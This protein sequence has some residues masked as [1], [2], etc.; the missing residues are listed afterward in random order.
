MRPSLFSVYLRSS[1]PMFL[2]P[3]IALQAI[4]AANSLRDVHVNRS[5][6][7]TLAVYFVALTIGVLG[8]GITLCV[9]HLPSWR[10]Q[11]L[12]RGTPSTRLFDNCLLASFI[13]SLLAVIA[14]IA[15]PTAVLSS[16]G[17]DGE[18]VTMRQTLE[19]LA[20][21]AS[22][23]SGAGLGAWLSSLRGSIASILARGLLGSAAV[24]GVGLYLMMPWRNTF[25][26]PILPY[27]GFQF[28]VFA[29]GVASARRSHLSANDP[30]Q[31]ISN[32]ALR[33]AAPTSALAC[34][35]CLLLVLP[36][37]QHEFANSQ[38]RYPSLAESKTDPSI[39][40]LTY[41][42]DL[43]YLVV[44]E[45]HE[46]TGATV[47]HQDLRS[48]HFQWSH[49]NH[50]KL[51][52]AHALFKLFDRGSARD[53]VFGSSWGQV[54]YSAFTQ[55]YLIRETGELVVA[56]FA[57]PRESSGS[58]K[59][60]SR[61]VVAR[62]DGRRF[63]SRADVIGVIAGI[64][65]TEWSGEGGVIL[66]DPEDG[67]LH[68]L[69]LENVDDPKLESIALPD[70]DRYLGWRELKRPLGSDDPKARTD[71]DGHRNSY[72]VLGEKRRY[73]I[74][75]DF[76]LTP[77]EEL[78]LGHWR[79][80]LRKSNVEI[81]TTGDA[82]HFTVTVKDDRGETVIEHV[83]AP[84]TT[85]EKFVATTLGA[86][87]TLRPLPLLAIGFAT[88]P[89]PGKLYV[90]D[91]FFDPRARGGAGAIWLGF[92]TIVASLLS[93]SAKRRLAQLGAEPS[94]WRAWSICYFVFGPAAWPA[95]RLLE[96]SRAYAKEPVLEP[97]STARTLVISA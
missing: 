52:D 20:I 34:A 28:A 63:S 56:N 92:A 46:P 17:R 7:V 68:R 44:D 49:G 22:V 50:E 43:R 80:D 4:I 11:L 84:R 75:D 2:G 48:T 37:L 58:W 9:S 57:R 12:H 86:L 31:P 89:S 60:A 69:N 21:G 45:N 42:R 15:I 71:L 78:E 19:L 1:L 81:A 97:R 82:L 93:W 54:A 29:I 91:S 51:G 90:A 94:R 61:L 96:T 53:F 74:A 59:P 32:E 66:G 6:E 25:S 79:S 70:G 16:F 27:L 33:F 35:T 88:D 24:I 64:G 41:D 67:T 65:A 72:A 40:R 83:Y 47:E 73:V 18:L 5:D 77:A 87:A 10:M 13:P 23:F 36:L 30:D 38:L 14:G 55:A 62:P 26:A 76:S 95:F 3:V 8:A 39:R 85:R